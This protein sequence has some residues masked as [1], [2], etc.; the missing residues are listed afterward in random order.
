M[1]GKNKYLR[2]KLEFIG[3]TYSKLLRQVRGNSVND[4]DFLELRILLGAAIMTTRPGRPKPNYATACLFL[5]MVSVVQIS[6]VR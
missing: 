4:Y 1:G 5:F 3:S 6:H 2:K